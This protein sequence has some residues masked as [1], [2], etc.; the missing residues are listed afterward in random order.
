MGVS[1]PYTIWKGK[2]S[3]GFAYTAGT[4]YY[5]QAGVRTTNT[6]A[7]GRGVLSAG[8]ALTF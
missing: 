5:R 1:V 4:G 7:V 8:Y 6:S 3:V 2:L